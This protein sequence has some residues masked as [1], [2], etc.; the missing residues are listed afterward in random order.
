M[1]AQVMVMGPE[2][3]EIPGRWS[4]FAAAHSRG[5]ELD[6]LLSLVIVIAAG[7][8]HGGP[9]VDE[10]GRLKQRVNESGELMLKMVR[11]GR[12]GARETGAVFEVVRLERHELR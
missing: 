3:A 9:V 2:Y 7:V 5:V 11:S 4:V 12:T 8:V 6:E 10:S 1:S